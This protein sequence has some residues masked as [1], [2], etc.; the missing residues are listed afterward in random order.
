MEIEEQ[1]TIKTYTNIF[2]EAKT[3]PAR[4]E[5]LIPTVNQKKIQ[6][7]KIGYFSL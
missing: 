6:V 3:E 5:E 2:E 4:V 1:T 7:N